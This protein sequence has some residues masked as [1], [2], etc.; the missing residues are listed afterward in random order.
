VDDRAGMADVEGRMNHDAEAYF[1]PA[2]IPA[3]F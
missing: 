1:I 2:V 3:W